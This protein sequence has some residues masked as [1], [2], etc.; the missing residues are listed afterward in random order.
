MKK[1]RK[2]AVLAEPKKKIEVWFAQYAETRQHPTNRLL[3]FIF[4][5]LMVFS[6]LGL[7]WS[8]PF[9]YL[10]FLGKYNGFVNWASFLI[11]FGGYYYY[12][13][14]P[15]LLYLMI[16]LVFITALIIVQ[17]EKWVMVGGP[18]IWL[19]CTITFIISLVGLFIGRS[20]EGKQHPFVV[21]VKNL[22]IG[23][24][25]VLHFICLKIG[26]KY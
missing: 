8:I 17:L 13:I 1:E 23:P 25:W 19:V 7:F 4:I 15:V 24:I 26:V 3:H 2:G 21:T 5:P 16:M 22:L 10:E 14:S 20:L 9:P 11:A 12:R 18:A 6:V